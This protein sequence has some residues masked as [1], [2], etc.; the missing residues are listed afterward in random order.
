MDAWLGISC[1][2]LRLNRPPLACRPPENRWAGR[3][4]TSACNHASVGRGA[5][6]VRLFT[7]MTSDRLRRGGHLA[8][9][10]SISAIALAAAPHVMVAHEEHGHP[11]R[12]HEGSCQDLGP[13]SVRLNGV[14]GSVD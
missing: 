5:C 6:S 4:P 11:A 10:V 7:T 9:A 3:V 14:G 2:Y 12:I 8:I 1:G 13:V